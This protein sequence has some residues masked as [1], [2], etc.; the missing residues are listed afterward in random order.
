MDSITIKLILVFS[1][2]PIAFGCVMYM[3]WSVNN[4]FE[5]QDPYANKVLR[6]PVVNIVVV[7]D[8]GSFGGRSYSEC[9]FLLDNQ[10]YV[11][12]EHPCLAEKG[13]FLHIKF[14]GWYPSREVAVQEYEYGNKSNN[15]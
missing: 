14:Y 4:N 12:S 6:V 1:M 10:R 13:D 5:K 15:P 9:V 7:T 3:N 11:T 2:I 8:G